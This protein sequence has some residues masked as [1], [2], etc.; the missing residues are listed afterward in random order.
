MPK[1]SRILA[2]AFEVAEPSGAG[3]PGLAEAI[4]R[5]GQLISHSRER[6]RLLEAVIDNFPGGVSL[7][8]QDLN[9]V[10]CNQR[11]RAL[12]DYPD[13]LFANGYPS[14]ET[15]F[16]FNA[17]RGEYGPG[18][19]E[20]HVA[21][22][23]ALVRQREAHV[24]ERTRPNGT[25]VEVRGMPIEGGGFVTTYFDVTEQ[26]RNQATIA[27]MAHHDALTDL[28][29]R[30]LFSD[31]LHGALALARR[32]ALMAVHYLDLDNFKP[33][34]D[35]FGHKAGDRLLIDV[36]GR[37]RAAVRD[38]DTVARLG[39]DEFAIIQTGITGQTDV[40]ALARRIIERFQ[41]PFTVADSPVVVGVSIGI[42]LAP[43]DALG[44]DELLQKADTALYRSK[45]G[46]RGQFSFF[47]E[48][49]PPLGG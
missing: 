13:E 31:R 29:N 4:G 36:A 45:S 26:R 8:D 14:M 23:L 43:G 1:V 41:S 20:M 44:S 33:V 5:M 46:G 48:P 12:L 6:I 17:E 49:H 3:L 38:N 21:R 2:N 15:L 47:G 22:R 39:G 34:N 35:N 7:F 42:A 37:L 32:G 16:R 30:M 24:Y 19:I 25:I 40:S 10:V 11:Q 27:H 28:P 9:M 18:D